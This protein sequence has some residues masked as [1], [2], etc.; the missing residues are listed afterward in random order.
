MIVGLIWSRMPENI[1]TGKVRCSAAVRK[2]ATTTSSK[3][4]AKAKIAPE[5]TPGR[6]IG[7]VTRKKAEAPEAPRLWAARVRLVS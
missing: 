7:S 2:R 1:C 3:E 5:I 6:I 4:V